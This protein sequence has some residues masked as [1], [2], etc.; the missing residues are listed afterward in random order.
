MFVNYI[1]SKK[2]NLTVFKHIFNIKKKLKIMFFVFNG[3][4]YKAKYIIAKSL[5][6]DTLKYISLS[7]QTGNSTV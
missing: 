6:A 4:A 2:F 5:L 3:L 1:L 7:L